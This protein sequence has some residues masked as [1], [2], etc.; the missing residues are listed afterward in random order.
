MRRHCHNCKTFLNVWEVR[1]PCCHGSA[2]RWLHVAAVGVF[3]LAA[4]FYLL[5]IVR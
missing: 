3:S 4:A 2:M 1:C 5:V